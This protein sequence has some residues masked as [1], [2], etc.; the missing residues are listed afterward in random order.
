M[1]RHTDTLATFTAQ[2]S[3]DCH[4]E[5]A[6][7]G[8]SRTPPV[9][10]PSA[11]RRLPPVARVRRVHC[12]KPSAALSRQRAHGAAPPLLIANLPILSRPQA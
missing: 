11:L 9:L 2:L 3:D 10:P 8:W 7:A 1:S 4:T 5:H 6:P 12:P